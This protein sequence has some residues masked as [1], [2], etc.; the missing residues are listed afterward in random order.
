MSPA[1]RVLPLYLA[2]VLTFGV[3]MIGAVR[4]PKQA[5]AS[6]AG[7][8]GP[9]KVKDKIRIATVLLP[10]HM[11]DDGR[12][13]E[14]EIIVAALAGKY[15]PDAIE[16]YV[17]PFSRHW[18]AFQDESRYDAVTTVPLDLD[19]RLNPSVP[20]IEYENGI[21][22]RSSRFPAGLGD[23]P[24]EA[25]RASRIV[26]FAGASGILEL[27]DRVPSFDLY[28]ERKDQY[29][30]SVLF[31]KDK[32]DAVI[33]DRLIFD[34]YNQ[35]VIGSAYPD[36]LKDLQFDVAFCPT[37]YKMVFRKAGDREEFD[38]GITALRRS[39]A[40]QQIDAAYSKRSRLGIYRT[41]HKGCA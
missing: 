14:A 35:S 4:V 15:A 24:L 27:E 9:G 3:G 37:R 6:A 2:I 28:L 8:A 23:V 29:S 39:G 25:L 22:Y 7:T 1:L 40:L 41:S 34:F 33:A 31:M 21:A 26:A 32:V 38:K 10:P 16:F 17:L 20:Y 36:Q 13:R 19:L 12:G 18:Q 11:D 5:E 30:H